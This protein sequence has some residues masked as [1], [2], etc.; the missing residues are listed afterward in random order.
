MGDIEFGAC[1]VCGK[2]RELTRTYYRYK[3]K[4][5]CHSPNHFETVR[6]CSECKP[7]EPEYTD[8]MIHNTGVHVRLRTDR[9]ANLD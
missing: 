7:V 2:E 9:L 4:C 6:H 5:D 8:V 3:I 1:E